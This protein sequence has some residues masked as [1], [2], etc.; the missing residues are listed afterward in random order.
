MRSQ[1][2]KPAGRGGDKETTKSK[3]TDED[4]P[5]VDETGSIVS[6]KSGD[7]KDDMVGLRV[8]ACNKR[9]GMYYPG[10]KHFHTL[11]KIEDNQQVIFDMKN[12][13]RGGVVRR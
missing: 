4:Q 13:S 8:I 5:E 7:N 3:K 12:I 6:D 1:A 11:R 10:N 2:N 9:D